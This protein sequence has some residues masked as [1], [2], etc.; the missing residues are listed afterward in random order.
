MDLLE[1]EVG[2]LEG[3]LAAQGDWDSWSIGSR[4]P[5]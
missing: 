5:R 3:R 2:D 4:P 1:V